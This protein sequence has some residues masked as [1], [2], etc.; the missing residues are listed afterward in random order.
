MLLFSVDEIILLE[1]D[2]YQ[3]DATSNSSLDYED[4]GNESLEP[5]GAKISN[6]SDY[7]NEPN[8]PPHLTRIEE[9][10][11]NERCRLIRCQGKCEW[12]LLV[13]TIRFNQ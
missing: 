10:H 1:I 3:I 5:G 7:C 4:D 11:I 12:N 2:Q 9:D 8:I 13:L 6:F